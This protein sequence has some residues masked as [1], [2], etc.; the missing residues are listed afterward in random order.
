MAILGEGMG[1]ALR[2]AEM[3]AEAIS[4]SSDL[5]L[6]QQKLQ[7]D[8]IELWR[9]RRLIWR[10][11]G[12]MVSRPGLCEMVVE[13]MKVT[14]SGEWLVQRAKATNEAVCGQ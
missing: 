9:W 10:G 14:N 11:V 3:A 13:V 12:M 8:F 5:R 4:S 2:S 7:R 6:V 1:L